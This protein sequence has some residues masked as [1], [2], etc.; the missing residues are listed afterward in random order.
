MSELEVDTAT[1]TFGRFSPACRIE[2]KHVFD[3]H[4]ARPTWTD[5]I[6]SNPFDQVRD[7]QQFWRGRSGS[8]EREFVAHIEV[9]F[10]HR[11]PF[12]LPL[13]TAEFTVGRGS[14]KDLQIVEGHVSAD[15]AVLKLQVLV[16][17]QG[18]RNGT[19]VNGNLVDEAV[20][21]DGDWIEFGSPDTRCRVSFDDAVKEDTSTSL[22]IRPPRPP[23]EPG[24]EGLREQLEAL[25]KTLQEAEIRATK[26]EQLAD[27]RE[28][29]LQE[30]RAKLAD[31]AND[32][33]LPTKSPLPAAMTA[34]APDAGAS[35]DLVRELQLAQRKIESLEGVVALKRS[36]DAVSMILERDAKIAELELDLKQLRAGGGVALGDEA[37]PEAARESG[38]ETGPDSG[39]GATTPATPAEQAAPA[40]QTGPL[41]QVGRVAESPPTASTP[42][43]AATPHEPGAAGESAEVVLQEFVAR[44][45]WSLHFS[46]RPGSAADCGYL[47]GSVMKF[48]RAFEQYISRFL[49]QGRRVVD[50]DVTQLD[51]GMTEKLPLVV[52][53]LL[54]RGGDEAR[55]ALDR[56]LDML[57]DKSNLCLEAGVEAGRR[58]AQQALEE[59]SPE[60]IEKHCNVSELRKQVL[61]PPYQV[62]WR[63]L[64][65]VVKS[66]GQNV[67]AQIED[68]LCDVVREREA[69]GRL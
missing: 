5:S 9:H 34:A 6:A 41:E 23:E 36:R 56:Y 47:L 61:G 67:D 4:C 26:A 55:G 8:D 12:E 68:A 24:T 64:A 19:R 3:V 40:D 51:P 35:A 33:E 25:T 53:K 13:G 16:R 65:D 57:A 49:Q 7:D 27:T 28:T 10:P 60:A 22:F 1:R 31:R 39:P 17:D 59:V 11:E 58:W 37:A 62:Y 66:L 14:G 45:G 18:S 32:T 20:A 69:K 44:M 15:H 38:P 54:E 42:H 48:C 29:Q 43:E 52:H 63:R 21:G 50:N 46:G 30:L 2:S